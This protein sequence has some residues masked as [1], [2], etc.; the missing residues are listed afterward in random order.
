MLIETPEAVRAR[1]AGKR[2]VFTNGVFDILHAGH[3]Q[4]L[5]QCRELGEALVVGLN[6]DESVRRLKGPNR[7][8]NT[9]E[10]RAAVVAALRCVDAVVAF[11]E[12]DPSAVLDR[13]RPDIHVKGGD[14]DAERMPETPV[15]RAYGGKVVILP[16][17]E[18]RSTTRILEALGEE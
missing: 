15:V 3:V 7:P 8:V 13:L 1:L 12:A 6:T 2:V 11:G 16:L 18:G 10:D 4:I 5:Q 14:Y 9:L 17:L